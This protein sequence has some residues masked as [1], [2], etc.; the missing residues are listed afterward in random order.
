MV[1]VLLDRWM[2]AGVNCRQGLNGRRTLF[3]HHERRCFTGRGKNSQEE[4]KQH[5]KTTL[6]HRI[7][8]TRAVRRDFDLPQ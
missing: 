3:R 6:N 2:V 8:C 1:A 4:K 7:P 5:G